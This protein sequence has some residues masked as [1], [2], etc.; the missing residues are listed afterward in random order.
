MLCYAILCY[1]ML[2][3]LC[4]LCYVC[5]AMYA[6]L[7]MYGYPILFCALQRL[8]KLMSE[9]RTAW[10]NAAMTTLDANPC[11][12]LASHLPPQPYTLLLSIFLMLSFPLSSSPMRFIYLVSRPPL[13]APGP[14]T[15]P[16]RSSLLPSLFHG[17]KVLV[18]PTQYRDCLCYAMLCYAMLCYA[19]LCYVCMYVCIL[20]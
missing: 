12:P 17:I 18:G 4:M 15:S 11:S 6:M 1:A 9:R 3:M 19:M 14:W 13:G 7:A 16:P 5:Y 8:V 10:P 20:I 2:C